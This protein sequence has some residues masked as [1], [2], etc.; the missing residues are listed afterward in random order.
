MNVLPWIII[1]ALLGY[2][3]WGMQRTPNRTSSAREKALAAFR[4]NTKQGV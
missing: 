1:I 2:G 4:K 3:L